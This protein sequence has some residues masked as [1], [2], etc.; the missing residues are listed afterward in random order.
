MGLDLGAI[1]LSQGARFSEQFAVPFQTLEPTDPA[2]AEIEFIRI[3]HPDDG[4]IVSP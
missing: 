2:N 1:G 4:E 3:H